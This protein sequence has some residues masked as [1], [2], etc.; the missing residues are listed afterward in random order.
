MI[1]FNFS[2]H[3]VGLFFIVAFS[4]H[5]QSTSTAEALLVS[6]ANKMLEQQGLTEDINLQVLLERTTSFQVRCLPYHGIFID[7]TF[8]LFN[9]LKV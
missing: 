2:F 9:Y 3:N 4:I 1:P 5:D 7:Y 8:L 6:K